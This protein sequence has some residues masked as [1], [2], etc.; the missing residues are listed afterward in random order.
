MDGHFEQG[1][2]H[3]E[4]WKWADTGEVE[5]RLHAYS[6][7]ADNGPLL[8]RLGFRLIGRRRQLLFYR[9]ACRRMRTLTQAQLEVD[10]S[11]SEHHVRIR[12]DLKVRSTT[13]GPA[14][15]E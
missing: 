8:L 15:H 13:L 5:F 11:A 7:V 4:V 12:E 3:Y 10:S 6:R 14:A 2:L 9:E 1:R